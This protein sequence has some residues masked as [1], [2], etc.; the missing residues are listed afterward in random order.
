MPATAEYARQY[1]LA[2]KLKYREA[3]NRYYSNNKEDIKKKRLKARLSSGGMV[4]AS[5]LQKYNISI[6]TVNPSQ[7]KV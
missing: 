2:H 4:R 5:T 3:D 1:Y 7:V 6:A